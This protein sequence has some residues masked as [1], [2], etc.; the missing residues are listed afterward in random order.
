MLRC[1]RAC[2][3]IT[4]AHS[5][6]VGISIFTGKRD[7]TKYCKWIIQYSKDENLLSDLE[8]LRVKASK[9]I[10]VL[11]YSEAFFNLTGYTLWSATSQTGRKT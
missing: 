8:M 9:N 11:S 1:S 3:A 2:S 7:H 6:F 4:T 10:Q 5:N